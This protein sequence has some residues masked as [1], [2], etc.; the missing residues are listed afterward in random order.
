M[1]IVVRAVVVYLLLWMLLRAM[2]KRELTELTA[3][4]MVVLVTLGDMVQ[5]G[6]TQE[7]MS[8]TGAALA[9]STFGLLAV[10]S[11]LVSRKFRWTRTVLTGRP[12][13]VLRQ[14]ELV[15]GTIRALR[16]TTDDIHEAARKSGYRSL[17]DLEWIIVEDDGKFSFIESAKE[18]ETGASEA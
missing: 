18:S 11:S 9:V 12:S 2:G 3:F 13:V 7:D 6:V 8:V 4:E 14:G 16:M 15:P 10:G 1:E 5:Q 17:D